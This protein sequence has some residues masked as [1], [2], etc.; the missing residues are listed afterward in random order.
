MLYVLAYRET[1]TGRHVGPQE[2]TFYAGIVMLL[3]VV[4]WSAMR[5]NESH[6]KAERNEQFMSLAMERIA[7]LEESKGGPASAGAAWPWG[8]HETSLLR[9]LGAAADRWWKLYDPERPDTAPT[10]KEVI[11]WLMAEKGVTENI[12]KAIATILR[13]DGLRTGPRG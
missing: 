2:A 11:D 10:N 4:A 3:I 1:L 13:A 6:K 12:A 7:A 8:T 9:H 5:F